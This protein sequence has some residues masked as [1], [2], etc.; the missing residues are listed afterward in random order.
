MLAPISSQ[1]L[2]FLETLDCLILPTAILLLSTIED[3]PLV[4]MSFVVNIPHIGCW[5]GVV[6]FARIV[7]SVGGKVTKLEGLVQMGLLFIPPSLQISIHAFKVKEGK[8][9]IGGRNIGLG[10][11]IFRL[12]CAKRCESS[13]GK[14]LFANTA[15]HTL[16][17]LTS[18]LVY[19]YAF[20]NNCLQM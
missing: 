19:V 13:A 4:A 16:A 11:L 14:T 1:Y 20:A 9:F 7:P 2:D 6:S 12:S 3:G 8:G 15:I 18:K 17:L 10:G 5:L